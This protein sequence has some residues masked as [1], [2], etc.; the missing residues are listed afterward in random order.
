MELRLFI[1]SGQLKSTATGND[2]VSDA[3]HV[4]KTRA[5]DTH[6][7]D[8]QLSP[9]NMFKSVYPS[10]VGQRQGTP[11]HRRADVQRQTTIHSYGPFRVTSSPGPVG[12]FWTVVGS[13]RTQKEPT[14]TQGGDTADH[15]ATTM[16]LLYSRV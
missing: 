3:G 15:C 5:T 1:P 4:I 9:L 11:V 6:V 10:V 16:P 7:P 2:N 14:R 8:D 13:R 12:C